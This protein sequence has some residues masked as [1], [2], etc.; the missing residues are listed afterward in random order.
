M[1]RVRLSWCKLMLTGTD[2]R[3]INKTMA[4]SEMQVPIE[5]NQQ[6]FECFGDE[7]DKRIWGPPRRGW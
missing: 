4:A 2:N 5:S 1:L 7:Q 3:S 6:I